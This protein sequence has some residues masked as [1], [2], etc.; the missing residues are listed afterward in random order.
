V[1]VLLA[2]LANWVHG[3]GRIS[4]DHEDGRATTALD[5]S[6]CG[7]TLHGLEG[8]GNAT[9]P[10]HGPQR[11]SEH[12]KVQLHPLIRTQAGGQHLNEAHPAAAVHRFTD[13]RRGNKG[14][15]A[16]VDKT[17]DDVASHM[18]WLRARR[19]GGGECPHR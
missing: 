9:L 2:V 4:S 10:V 5:E 16:V 6:C 14:R 18:R 3:V 15:H 1:G 8:A 17:S 13:S 7:L 12:R 19:S 11:Y